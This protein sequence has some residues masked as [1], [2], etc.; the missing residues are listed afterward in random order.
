MKN[1]YNEL[2]ESY[3][4]RDYGKRINHSYM[5]EQC[6]V[7]LKIPLTP[8]FSKGEILVPLFGM[9]HTVHTSGVH[10]T[11]HSFGKEGLGEILLNLN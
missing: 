8:P 11:L 1:L 7:N 4:S 5:L 3:N 9:K 10:D 2:T 6:A